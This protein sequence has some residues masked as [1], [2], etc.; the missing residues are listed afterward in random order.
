MIHSSTPS[1]YEFQ[2]FDGYFT[3][4]SRSRS[5]CMSSETQTLLQ[6]RLGKLQLKRNCCGTYAQPTL[7]HLSKNRPSQLFDLPHFADSHWYIDFGIIIFP[8]AG[9]S[10]EASLIR[11]MEFNMDVKPFLTC[12]FRRCVHVLVGGQNARIANSGAWCHR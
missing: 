5:L 6:A 8:A 7:L 3:F 9:L 11:N 10:R 1:S 2:T 12:R 4:I